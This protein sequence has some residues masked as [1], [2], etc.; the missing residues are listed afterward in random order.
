MKI[1][2]KSKRKFKITKTMEVE[3][4]VVT[5]LHQFDNREAKKY[6]VALQVEGS[7]PSRFILWQG[8]EYDKADKSDKGVQEAIKKHFSK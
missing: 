8:K 1:T 7:H 6:I 2:L 5:V 3:T 4:N